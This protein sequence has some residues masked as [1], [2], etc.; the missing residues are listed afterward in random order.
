M[1]PSFFTSVLATLLL[2]AAISTAH[3]DNNDKRLQAI[4]SRLGDI[5][6][7]L[8]ALETAKIK[9]VVTNEILKLSDFPGPVSC[10]F[11]T[12]GEATLG[13]TE[14]AHAYCARKFGTPSI[15]QV[16]GSN[17]DAQVMRV[18]CVFTTSIK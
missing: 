14:N 9:L 15:G 3:A 1:R 7:R 10:S 11:N 6:S 2:G 17:V 4:E 18:I 12:A 13:C 16:I 5:E 8:N